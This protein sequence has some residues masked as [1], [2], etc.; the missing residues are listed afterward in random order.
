MDTGIND[1]E[2]RKVLSFYFDN[3]SLVKFQLGGQGYCRARLDSPQPGPGSR[4]EK[5]RSA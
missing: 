1:M 4:S 5:M 3:A 2:S